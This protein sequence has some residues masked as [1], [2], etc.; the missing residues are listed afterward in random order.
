MEKNTDRK[1]FLFSKLSLII[2]ENVFMGREMGKKGQKTSLSSTL[3]E[4]GIGPSI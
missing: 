4:L 3:G 1:F 2:D